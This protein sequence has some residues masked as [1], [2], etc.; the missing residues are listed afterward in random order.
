[1]SIRRNS[2]LFAERF[3]RMTFFCTSTITDLPLTFLIRTD[4]ILNYLFGLC[5]AYVA[6]FVI[7]WL[8][9]FDDPVEETAEQEAP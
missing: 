6:G 9:G 3:Q 7:T 5:I 1:M 4:Q 8:V 2:Y